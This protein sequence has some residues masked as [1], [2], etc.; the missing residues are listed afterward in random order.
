M[1]MVGLIIPGHLKTYEEIGVNHMALHLR[2]SETPV[3]EA[4]AK[5]EE[6]VLPYFGI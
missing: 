4:I 1:R 6:K 3:S 5:I 2:K